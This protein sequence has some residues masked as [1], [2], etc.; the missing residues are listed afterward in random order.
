MGN[1]GITKQQFLDWALGRGWVRD[2]WGH[3]HKRKGDADYRFKVSRISVRYEVRSSGGWL[4]L[5]SRYFKDL[6]FGDDGK[7]RGLR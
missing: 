4:R 5:R 6:S 2:K 7:L 1:K 3:L